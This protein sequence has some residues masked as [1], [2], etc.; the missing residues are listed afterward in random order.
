MLRSAFLFALIAFFAAS[1]IADV[2]GDLVTTLPGYNGKLPQ[3]HYSGFVAS[4]AAESVYLHYWFVEAATNPKTAP[5]L[6]WLNGGPG[7]SSLDGLLSELGPLHFNGETSNG[8]PSLIDNPYAWSNVANVIFLESPAGVGFSYTKNGSTTTNDEITSQNNYGFLKNWLK[9][10]SEYANNP[11]YITGESYAGIYV[12]TFA[13]RVWEGIKSGDAKINFKGIAVGNGCWGNAVGTCAMYDGAWDGTAYEMEFLH[14]YAMISE[15]HWDAVVKYCGNFSD[16]NPS[17][18]CQDAVSTASQDGGDYNVY[19]IYDTCP[20]PVSA[21]DLQTQTQYTEF[22]RKNNKPLPTVHKIGTPDVCTGTE[23]VTWLNLPLVQKALHVDS[24][25]VSSWQICGGADYV[26]TLG[27][28]R[29]AYKGIIDN[30][31]TV[32]IYS[33]DV[34]S[35]VP[36]VGTEVWT[37]EL[38]YKEVTPWAPWTVQEQVMGYVTYYDKSF[39]Y[40]TVKGAGHMVPQYQPEAALNM[41]TRYLNGG[42][43]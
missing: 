39:T 40:L 4:D 22:L 13:Q 29:P 11:V 34:D 1:V 2:P 17:Q 5:V 15:P 33:G 41:I 28:A 6:V 43:F 12:P 19:S 31:Y 21:K 7:C 14:G 32:L 10:F 20:S 23:P 35:C 30:G 18:D 25:N 26:K 36:Y 42:K 38:G 37:R 3:R 24:A 8:V 9:A 27:D 16:P